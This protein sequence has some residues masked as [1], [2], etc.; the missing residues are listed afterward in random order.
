MSLPCYIKEKNLD[1]GLISELSYSSTPLIW[2]DW[3]G[4]NNMADCLM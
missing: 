4:E 2:N 3:I 1:N